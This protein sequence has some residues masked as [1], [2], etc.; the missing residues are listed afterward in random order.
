[1]KK[2]IFCITFLFLCKLIF[3]QPNADTIRPGIKSV[4]G[5]ICAYSNNHRD[6]TG[7]LIY[8]E[9]KYDRSGR[10][11]KEIAMEDPDEDVE[12]EEFSFYGHHH[13]QSRNKFD[14]TN[15]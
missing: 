8:T 12:G 2:I 9:K 11:I 4:K 7:L 1:M 13:V 15:Y 3:A 10:I 6:S 14:T 5:E